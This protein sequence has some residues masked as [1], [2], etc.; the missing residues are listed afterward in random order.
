MKYIEYK[1]A[2]IR[3]LD[4]CEH[5]CSHFDQI[6]DEKEKQNVRADTYYLTGYVFECILSYTIFNLIGYHKDKDVFALNNDN[7]C[8]LIF[9]RHF[10]T[11]NI[12]W[13][14]DY[15]SRHGGTGVSNVPILNGNAKCELLKKW[16]VKFRYTLETPPTFEEIET[17]VQLAKSTLVNIRTHI[18]KD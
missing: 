5:I 8:R 16:N 17:F 2:S 14:I 4:T 6:K 1:K 15:I 7:G 18:T 12:T 13:K 11:H 10:R 3:H 9:N